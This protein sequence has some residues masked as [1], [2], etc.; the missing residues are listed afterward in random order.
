MKEEWPALG[1][2][3]QA[4]KRLDQKWLQDAIT[5]ARKLTGALS[6]FRGLY[7]LS[8]AAPD[9]VTLRSIDAWLE[10]VTRHW[11]DIVESK[12]W[13]EG[14]EAHLDFFLDHRRAVVEIEIKSSSLE[15]STDLLKE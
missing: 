4:T 9:W 10:Q 3:Y 13:L 14:R 5:E 2:R 11:D 12:A 15:K 6:Y 8:P 1:T 7:R